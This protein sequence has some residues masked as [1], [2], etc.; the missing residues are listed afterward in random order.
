MTNSSLVSII[1]PTFNRAKYVGEALESIIAQT[2]TNWE[3]I[4]VDDG[5]TD[6]TAE[7]MSTFCV[8]D[9]RII[10][11]KRPNDYPKGVNGARN[12]GL[13]KSKGVY[14]AFCDDDDFWLFD[15]LEKQIPIFQAHPEV[16][17]VTGNIEFV[18]A[19]GVRRGRVIKQTGNH[20]YVF[21]DLLFKNRL[22][23]ITPVLRREVFEKVGLFNT[24]FKISED[25]EYWRRVAYYY[26]FYALPDVLACVRKHDANTSL[27]VSDTPYEQYFRYRELTK[28]L[29][30]W[31]EGRF[32]KADRQ[33]I[34]EVEA[35]RYKHLIRNHCPGIGNKLQL[36]KRIIR[37]EVNAGC[38]FV[39]LLLRF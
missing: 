18:N 19:D 12:F 31:G 34:A 9:P 32:T 24:D 15:K 23:M 7:I 16:G 39:Y 14:I 10:F 22:S 28:A 30:V 29:L 21:E 33:L 35:K 17:L 27:I 26:P 1:I 11:Y 2:Y 25:W 20:G 3:C 13:H 5:S 37:N 8:N 38:Y 36:F 6:D 4:V